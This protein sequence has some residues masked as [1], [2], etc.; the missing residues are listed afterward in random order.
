M[1]FFACGVH[2]AKGRSDPGKLKYLLACAHA[3]R[4]AKRRQA[5]GFVGNR[6]GNRQKDRSENL[7]KSKSS[8]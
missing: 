3:P 5:K 2:R 6:V 4:D 7:V 8:G 1:R